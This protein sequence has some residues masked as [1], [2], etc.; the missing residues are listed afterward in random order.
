MYHNS[1]DSRKRDNRKEDRICGSIIFKNRTSLNENLCLLKPSHKA[2]HQNTT[3]Q[4]DP[5]HQTSSL[6]VD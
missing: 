4:I 5:K 2:R 6:D 3:K 1:N